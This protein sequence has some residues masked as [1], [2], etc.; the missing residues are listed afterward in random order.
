MVHQAPHPI[1]AMWAAAAEL[2]LVDGPQAPHGFAGTLRGDWRC[3]RRIPITP[4]LVSEGGRPAAACVLAKRLG[5]A[6]RVI[7]LAADYTWS[8]LRRNV[9]S[10]LTLHQRMQWRLIAPSL[11]GAIAVSPMVA[12]D[13]RALYPALPVRVVRPFVLSALRDRLLR[14][15]PDLSGQRIVHLAAPGPKNGTAIVVQAFDAVR[16]RWP[17]AELHLIG[18]GSQGFTAPGVVAHGWVPDVTQHLA[19]ADL[20]VL[21]GLG[22]AYPISVLEALTAGIP[23]VVSTETG[24]KERVAEIDARLV[25]APEA[26]AV[27]AAINDYFSWPQETRRILGVRARAAAADLTAATQCRA[28]AQHLRELTA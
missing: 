24:A 3:A 28:F 20:F 1:H 14:C 18:H 10:P 11:D 16:R 4:L 26:A 12:D 27:A 15:A 19:A 13:L 22:Q 9:P 2:Q 23:C 8:R 6:Q 25:V 5:R 17:D 7:L 21:P